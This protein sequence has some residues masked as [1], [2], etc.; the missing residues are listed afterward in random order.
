MFIVIIFFFLNTF[1]GR[2]TGP[3]V[4]FGHF[5]D[6]KLFAEITVSRWFF[7]ILNSFL[8][9]WMKTFMAKTK[10]LTSFVTNKTMIGGGNFYNI[11]SVCDECSENRNFERKRFFFLTLFI[12]IK[13]FRSLFLDAENTN[14]PLT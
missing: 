5:S 10:I 13:S 4:S 12:V 14:L 2:N 8:K 1:L 11:W 3:K 7:K 9:N 6:L